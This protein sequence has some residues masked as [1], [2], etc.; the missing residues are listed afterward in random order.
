MSKMEGGDRSVQTA[1]RETGTDSLQAYR[2]T[3]PETASRTTSMESR[4]LAQNCTTLDCGTMEQLYGTKSEVGRP[5]AETRSESLTPDQEKSGDGKF[6]SSKVDDKTQQL[7]EGK[8][9]V[10]RETA[11][12]A[13]GE[14]NKAGQDPTKV[15]SDAM[16]DNRVVAFG[17]SH[18]SPNPQRDFLAQSM[19][20]L[21]KAGAT[22]LAIE[23]PNTIQ[24]ALDEYMKTGKLDPSVLPGDWN[25]PDCLKI[26]ESAR[27]NGL[28]IQ[29]VDIPHGKAFGSVDRDGAMAENVGNI[30]KDDPNNKVVFWAGSQHLNQSGSKDFPTAADTLKKQYSM[31]TINPI[32]SRGEGGGGNVL[33]EV[34][35]GVKAPVAVKGSD[36]PT[37]GSLQ[38]FSGQHAR[39]WDYT[40]VYPT[41]EK[42]K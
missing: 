11:D 25:S 8:Y 9:G 30:L 5:K 32:Y 2:M 28:K 35:E 12:Q 33:G 36:A 27:A 18:E 31:A 26:L 14:I 24:P 29:A 6:V 3:Q 10:S 37:F 19:A 22:H 7:L 4:Q 34:T 20:D 23:A 38:P 16:K 42:K 39:D 41:P 21:K 13:R 1:T 15:V 17:E 40:I